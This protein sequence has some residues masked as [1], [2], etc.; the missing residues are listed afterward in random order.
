MLLCWINERLSL[1]L[2][3][4]LSLCA[5]IRVGITFLYVFS[6]APVVG[7]MKRYPYPTG[8]NFRFQCAETSLTPFL[9][10]FYKRKKQPLSPSFQ[11]SYPGIC[12]IQCTKFDAND[13]VNCGPSNFQKSLQGL[14]ASHDMMEWPS[15][16]KHETGTMPRFRPSSKW[17]M[18]PQYY[19]E[20]ATSHTSQE[21]WPRNC[22]SPKESVQRPSPTHLQHHV[23]LVTDPQV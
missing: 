16:P 23:V 11:Y 19:T 7:V 12:W 2:S 9:W 13:H 18:K 15:A 5:C 3:L 4:S 20:G 14:L 1:S 10:F 22:E 8:T 6:R 17:I 21:P